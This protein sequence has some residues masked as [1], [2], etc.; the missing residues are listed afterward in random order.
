MDL[1]NFKNSKILMTGGT[2]FVGK[3]F[4]IFAEKNGIQLH[5]IGSAICNLKKSEDVEYFFEDE[6]HVKYD[7]IF[8]GAALQGAGDFTLKHPAEQIYANSL[9]HINML[10]A[11]KKYQPQARFIGLGSTCSYPGN[12]TTLKETDYLTGKLHESVQYYGLTKMLMQQGIEAYKDQYGLKGTTVA[13]ATLFGKYD[14]MDPDRSHVVTAL[15]KKF[16]DAEKYD[17]SEVEIWGDGT[18]TRELIFVED[19]ILG[20]LLVADYNGPIINIGTG[21][22]ISIR[23]LAELIKRLS[24]FK[25]NIIYN[26]N[27]FVGVKNKVQDISFAKEQFGWTTEHKIHHIE[28]AL[29]KTIDWYNSTLV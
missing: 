15:I 19:Q 17:Y 16:C 7:Y 4:K 25:G 24:G 13:F 22:E 8:H 27:R 3:N 1:S 26:T 5:C 28:S 6:V 9:I 21:I 18:Q 10:E 29:I 12:L 2:G 11:W 20:M 14:D 23:E